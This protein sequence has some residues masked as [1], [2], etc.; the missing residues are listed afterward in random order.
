MPAQ[1]TK[2]YDQAMQALYNYM[3]AYIGMSRERF[4]T[5]AANFIIRKFDRK[6][7]VIKPGEVDHYFNFI[8]KGVA[9]KFAFAGK[10]E[11]TL[12]LSTEGHFIHSE[13][14]FFT[15]TP[16]DCYVETIE[17]TVF[18]SVKYDVLEN[19]YTEMPELNKLARMMIG[20]MYVKKEMRDQAH[21]RLTTKERFLQYVNRHPDMIQR[22]S[23][24]YIASYLN[25]KP[26][27]FSRLKHLLKQSR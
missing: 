26:E 17:P 1:G 5:L 25:I 27:T 10:K 18:L 24:K 8:L 19:L 6:T 23:Q 3:N 21:L 16:S 15:Q 14:S 7:F 20:E 4:N 2:E 22:V 11:I 13:I 12:Q 9:R